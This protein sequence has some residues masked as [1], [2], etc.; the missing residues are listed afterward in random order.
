MERK[1]WDGKSGSRDGE[2]VVALR[3]D[4]WEKDVQREV[5]TARGEVGRVGAG[6]VVA[7][8]EC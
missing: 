5:K 7:V 8:G 3:V 1:E 6:V 2:A 4:W